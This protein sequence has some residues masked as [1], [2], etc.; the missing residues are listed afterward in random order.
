M[1]NHAEAA[2]VVAAFGDFYIRRVVWGEAKAW[3]GKVGDVAGLWSNEVENAGFVLFE[4]AAKNRSSFGDL[5]ETDESVHFGEFAHEVGGK[6]LRKA[7]AYDDLG[8]GALAFMTLAG[9]LENG[10]DGFLLC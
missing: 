9:G 5:I 10:I 7:S 3:G 1:R 2:R 6:A 8:V 4:H